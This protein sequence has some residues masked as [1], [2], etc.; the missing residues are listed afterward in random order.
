M[1]DERDLQRRITS[2]FDGTAPS[3]GPDDLLEDVFTVTGATRP[4]PRWWARLT[5]RPMRYD[6]TL[7]SG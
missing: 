4:K 3:H 5:E 6:A 2:V 7:V 1:N